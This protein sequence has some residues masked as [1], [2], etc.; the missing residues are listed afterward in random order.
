MGNSHVLNCKMIKKTGFRTEL[1]LLALCSSSAFSQSAGVTGGPAMAGM[2]TSIAQAMA[3]DDT[4]SAALS[5]N[6]SQGLLDDQI[7]A[8]Q[9]GA[10]LTP[11]KAKQAALNV[12]NQGAL[13]AA[14]I[15]GFPG[16]LSSFGSHLFSRESRRYITPTDLPV[17][18]DYIVGVGDA[19]EIR[20]FG[21]ENKVMRLE[22]DRT[23]SITIPE[24]G[25]IGV[26]GMSLESMGKMLIERIVKQKIGVE[27][28]VSMGQMRSIQVFLMGDVNFPGALTTDALTTV[29]NAL[30]YGGG[31]KPTGTMRRVEI[32]RQGKVVKQV[33][34]YDSLLRG[35]AGGEMRLQSG[36]VVFV[37]TVGKRVGIDGEVVR[38]A[39]YE[40]LKE[41]SVDDLVRLA[42][43]FRPTAYPKDSTLN[44]IGQDWQRSTQI[45]PLATAKQRQLALQDGDVF[46]IA[47]VVATQSPVDREPIQ[48]TVS[49]EGSVTTPGSYEWKP[50]LS[51]KDVLYR[52]YQL[53][54]DAFRP[55][56]LIERFEPMTGVKMLLSANLAEVISDQ[57]VVP[58][59]R[60]DRIYVFSWSEVDFLSS[61]QVQQ[62]LGGRLPQKT[63]GTG[64]VVEDQTPLTKATQLLASK[65]GTNMAEGP[66]SETAVSLSVCRGLVELA[67]VVS[68]EGTARFRSAFFPDALIDTDRRL[69]KSLPCPSV[70]EQNPTYLPFLLENT[71]AVRGEVKSPGLLPVP[72]GFN[73]KLTLLARGG[74]TREADTSG[75]EV[76]QAVDAPTGVVQVVRRRVKQVDDLA[77]VIVQPGD[78]V[79]VKKRATE[80]E[81]GIIKLN[82]EFMHPG[83]YEIRKGERLSELMA[84]A[85]GL[86]GHAYPFGAVFLR[87]QVK[88]EKRAYYAKAAN[89]LQQN[90]LFAMSRQSAG[91][92]QGGGTGGGAV[93][94]EMIRQLKAA[95]P[96]GRMVIE[97]D[98]TVLKMHPELD[99]V[100]ESGDEIFVPRR[101]SSILVMGEVLNPGAVQF[102]SGKSAQ[103][104]IRAVGGVTRLADQSRIY[105]VLPNGI[106]EPV[107]SSVWSFADTPLL[108]GSV[109]YVTR[110]ALPTTSL[111][112]AQIF[113]GML[114]D[115]AV[116]AASLIVINR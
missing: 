77:A 29:S 4:L 79:Q 38:P 20:Y 18:A 92:S 103:D 51:L 50:G 40:L 97:A 37:P 96:V 15:P 75:I 17:P 105:T 14:T 88:E 73:L 28:T 115:I 26:V 101:P 62:V 32:R 83:G 27:A 24:F 112:L 47:A 87:N 10:L 99:V 1:L 109:V 70:F 36:D 58:L 23:G 93:M 94:L 45:I 114:R 85:G 22:V 41:K 57:K 89:E 3:S 35:G 25:V 6:Q 49:L 9:Q 71:V 84:R 11:T 5:N 55:L 82:G 30:L 48:K 81:A 65:A 43:G 59:E 19:V 66:K 72:E 56:A 108:P 100:L 44:R 68:S 53:K 64:A 113:T 33:D 2:P 21:K 78:V 63:G 80:R 76:S 34:L 16:H 12:E 91:S 104:Y 116:A 39:V 106:S 95:E 90:A 7:K 107:K 31:I 8:A 69:V 54:P 74:V 46:G 42:G 111:D 110:E 86:T 61:L 102:E 60:T 52:T 98:P 67:Q 13:P